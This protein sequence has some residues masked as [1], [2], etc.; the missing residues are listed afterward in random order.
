M[1]ADLLGELHGQRS[2]EVTG[3]HAGSVIGSTEPCIA[4][5]ACPEMLSP[6]DYA[7][8]RGD[9][10]QIRLVGGKT[11]TPLDRCCDSW[12]YIDAIWLE[13]DAAPQSI[14]YKIKLT[15]LSWQSFEGCPR[16]VQI[17]QYAAGLPQVAVCIF[18]RTQLENDNDDTYATT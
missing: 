8:C 16:S 15:T 11:R 12:A 18:L 13:R 4:C 14:R 2:I 1:V 10:K 7:L 17:T 3:H 9:P 6:A 5:A